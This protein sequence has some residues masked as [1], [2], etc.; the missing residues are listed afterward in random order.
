MI[1]HV[2]APA[3]CTMTTPSPR[4]GV[5]AYSTRVGFRYTAVEA[6]LELTDS[7]LRCTLTDGTGY[8]GWIAERLRIPDLK[9][10]LRPV[11]TS[12]GVRVPR[13]GYHIKW[14]PW[15]YSFEIGRGDTTEWT[16]GFAEY[17]QLGWFDTLSNFL[18]REPENSGA[19]R[20]IHRRT[21][22]R[23]STTNSP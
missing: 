14:R 7:T 18:D 6:V 8:S 9:Q 13:N 17:G 11:S 19:M 20:W 16:V 12:R 4:S 5:L 2:R 10:R 23:A 3:R 22:F 21:D 1:Y 15:N